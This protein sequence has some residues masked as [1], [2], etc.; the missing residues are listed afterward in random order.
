M[1]VA[2]HLKIKLSE[3]D[4]R[5]RTF[6]P[7]YEEMLDEVA[8]AVA[9]VEK[10]QPAIIDLGIGT[11]ALAARCLRLKPQAR[12]LGIDADADILALARR[13]LAKK[14]PTKPDFILA[15]FLHASLPRCDA[16]VATLALHHIHQIKTKQHFYAKCFAALRRSGIFANGD[17]FMA[18]NPKLSQNYMKIWER[19]LCQF[20]NLRETR[21]FFAAWA[22]EDTYFPL[23][24]EIAMMSKAGFEVE[25]VWRQPPFAVLIGRKV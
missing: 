22:D 14:R 9:L 19:H 5:I 8:A 25:V 16:I 6:I 21:N 1:S 2:Q 4:Q 3:Y 7:H 23:R 13:R 20:Y 24:Q 11:G 15:N 10:P 18:E 17:C 12:L